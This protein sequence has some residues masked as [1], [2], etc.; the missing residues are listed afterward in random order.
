MRH[1]ASLLVLALF[2]STVASAQPAPPPPPQQAQAQLQKRER[3]KKRIRALRAYTLT[4]ELQLDE[5]TAGKLFPL[6][7]R[8]DDEFD[9]LLGA[10]ADLQKRLVAASTGNDVRAT[11]KVID[12]AVANQRAF[13]D[14]EDKRLIELR[15]ILTPAQTA[16]LLVVLPAWERKIE[17][18]LRNAIQG[19]GPGANPARDAL[20]DDD[21]AAPPPR[22]PGARPRAD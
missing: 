16:R 12:E 19:K 6:L 14:L 13:W 8:Y 2:G 20:D 5:V 21:D 11:N 7:A 4:E 15:K 9:K 10:R 17:N 22:R 3:I 18:Q 1:L